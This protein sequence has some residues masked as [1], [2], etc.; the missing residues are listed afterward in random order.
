MISENVLDAALRDLFDLSPVPFSISTTDHD[1]RYIKVNPAYL[2]LIGRTWGEIDGKPLGA[3]LPYSIDDPGR[4]ARMNL[5]ETQGFYKLAEVEMQHISG[6]IIPTLITAQ[7]RRI[8]GESFDIEI[9]LDNSERKA[10]EQAILHAAQVDAMTGIQNRSSFE[11]HLRGALANLSSE[12]RLFLAYIDLNRFKRVNDNF[13]HSV[14][15][16]LLR[17]IAKRLVEWG[18]TRDFIARLGGDEFGIVSVYQA[19]DAFS[20]SRFFDLAKTIAELTVI[21]ENL[22]QVG[23]AIGLAEASAGVSFDALLDRADRL[24]YAAKSSGDLIDVRS[25]LMGHHLLG[26][27]EKIVHRHKRAARF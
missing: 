15:D 3:D 2:H 24:M 7:R 5:L 21:D 4:L 20:L 16:Q 25:E 18:D 22:I 6:R 23:A 13:G 1:S 26:A 14:G 12:S 11:T 19:D 17:S 27:D 8:A 9:M 10:F